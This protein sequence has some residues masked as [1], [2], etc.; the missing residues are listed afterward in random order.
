MLT[1]SKKKT[2]LGK[3]SDSPDQETVTRS[4]KITRDLNE[5]LER[6]LRSGRDRKLFSDVARR[7]IQELLDREFREEES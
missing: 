2:S 5:R 7:A 4:L 3:Q 1:M 6:F